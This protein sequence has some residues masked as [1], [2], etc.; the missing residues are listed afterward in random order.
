MAA[1]FLAWSFPPWG[2][3][4]ALGRRPRGFQGREISRYEALIESISDI[5]GKPRDHVAFF[6]R[7][8]TVL[9][10]LAALPLFHLV[11]MIIGSALIVLIYDLS[12]RFTKEDGTQIRNA[13]FATGILFGVSVVTGAV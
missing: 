11:P 13:E 7:H 12:W 3:W 8:L 10:P 9:V 1:A 6:I 4:F 5:G 2:R